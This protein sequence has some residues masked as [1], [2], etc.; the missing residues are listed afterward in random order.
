LKKGARIFMLK[1]FKSRITFTYFLITLIVCVA[2]FVSLFASVV[3][4]RQE[5]LRQDLKR[6][7]QLAAAHIRGEDVLRVSIAPDC[8]KD[9]AHQ[10]LEADLRKITETDERIYDA[11]VMIPSGRPGIYLFVANAKPDSSPVACGEPFDASRFPEMLQAMSK[12]GVDKDITK[13]KWGRWL[14]GYAPIRDGSGKSVAFLGLDVA[15]NTVGELTSDFLKHLTLSM[16][17]AALL[18]VLIGAMS[19][20]WLAAPIAQIISG[21]E[22]VESGDLEYALKKSSPDEFNR[23]VSLFNRMTVALKKS[24]V[25]LAKTVKETESLNRELELAADLQNRA[26]PKAP[27]SGQGIDIAARNIPAREVGGDYYDFLTGDPGKVGFVIADAAG[28]GFPGSLFMTNSRSVFRVISAEEKMPSR[29]LERANDFISQDATVSGGMF[30][31]FLYAV[32]EKATKRLAYANAGHYP[33]FVF[34]FAN[35]KFRTLSAG[36]V[37]L[38]V[39][40]SQSYPEETV[41]LGSGDVV[42]MYTDGVTEAMN[43]KHEMFGLPRLMRLVEVGA[44]QNA[45]SILE[46]IERTVGAFIGAEPLFDDMTLLIFKVD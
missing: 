21:M 17:L 3:Q 14:S 40:E 19:S 18:A 45:V 29:T 5:T 20:R 35:K 36:G 30:I 6:T 39:F 26:L 23:I 37:P 22:K 1:S 46:S 33:P 11:Y 9:G 44:D 10:H 28:K 12:P 42:V 32:Y 16:I 27:P 24:M 4:K 13:D 31:T 38:G 2:L 15:E 7:A 34:N 25:D 43:S 41:Q 8:R